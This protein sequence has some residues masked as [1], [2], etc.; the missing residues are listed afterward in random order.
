MALLKGDNMPSK[1]TSASKVLPANLIR[2]IQEHYSGGLLYI[3][4]K[5]RDPQRIQARDK[6]V[7]ADKAKGMK[8]FD[9][10]VKRNI[11]IGTI[12]RIL[13]KHKQ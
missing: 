6:L 7:L 8:V 5:K 3:P 4:S 1:G 12:Y 2:K 13:A 10:A 11:G 9:I